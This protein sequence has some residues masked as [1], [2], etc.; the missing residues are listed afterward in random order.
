MIRR[1]NIIHDFEGL[2]FLYR[3][4]Y[5]FILHLMFEI[6]L[7]YNL[8]KC[9]ISYKKERVNLLKFISH[10]LIKRDN[11]YQQIVRAT[12]SLFY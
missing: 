12:A 4:T 9:D 6:K 3:I 8:N 11:K 5:L 10:Y 7:S 1:F 2:V